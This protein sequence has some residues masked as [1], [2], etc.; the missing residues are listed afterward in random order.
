MKG[1]IFAAFVL[2]ALTVYAK[3][4]PKV[5]PQPEPPQPVDVEV[6]EP[7]SPA[8]ETVIHHITHLVEKVVPVTVVGPTVTV[9][10]TQPAS[11][12]T[13]SPPPELDTIT[14]TQ[15]QMTTEESNTVTITKLISVSVYLPASRL[16]ASS[17]VE[18][19]LVLLN[20]PSSVTLD[21][22]A[23]GSATFRPLTTKCTNAKPIAKEAETATALLD[24][25]KNSPPTSRITRIVRA[26][27]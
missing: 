17:P 23:T 12:I 2:S 27:K 4:K 1:S 14:V 13:L 16:N 15:R 6:P 9:S 21:T 19:S 5:P 22:T 18:T 7:E 20:A 10:V 3:P 24:L 8:V 11:T 26:W 25:L